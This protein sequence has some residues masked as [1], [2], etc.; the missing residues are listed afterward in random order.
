MALSP[1]TG[2]SPTTSTELLVERPLDERI[3]ERPRP[4]TP[5]SDED[6]SGNPYIYLQDP[7]AVRRTSPTQGTPK[8]FTC[9]EHQ[10]STLWESLSESLKINF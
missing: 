9:I 1:T 3:S 4:V 7:S 8:N 5:K 10:D 2:L 6:G